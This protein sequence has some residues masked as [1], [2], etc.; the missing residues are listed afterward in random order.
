MNIILVIACL[1]YEQAIVLPKKDIEAANL[2]GL[3]LLFAICTS[4]FFFAIIQIIKQPILFIFNASQLDRYIW[5]IAPAILFGGIFSGLSYWNSRSKQ[6]GRIATA[7]IVS[8]IT[9]ISIQLAAGFNGYATGGSLIVANLMGSVAS[10]IILSSLVWRE[11]GKLFKKNINLEHM[12][13]GLYRYKKFPLLD[14]GS[15]LLNNISWQLPVL[16]FTVFF[17]S[18]VA[19][20]Y[21]L[22]FMAIQSP[23]SLIGGS[24]AQVFFQ[25][26]AIARGENELDIIVKGLF[27]FLILLSMFPMLSLAIIGR[28]L[29]ILL[30][31]EAWAE[32]GIYAQILSVWAIIWFVSGPMFTLVSVLEKQEYGFKFNVAI[33]ATRFLSIMIGVRFNSPRIAISLFAL[34]GILVYGYICLWILNESGVA[35]IEAIRILCHNLL[36]FIPAGIILLVIKLMGV[37]SLIEIGIAGIILILYFAIMVRDNRNY[38]SKSTETI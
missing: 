2:L 16:L 29:F 13:T 38:F 36:L 1:R 31:G 18:K 26:A 27:K 3:S 19:G 25:R 28:D 37:S 11:S 22:G 32:A 15:M 21:A 8:S 17:S 33:I 6:F 24:I 9:V 7:R 35:R 30:F 23:M 14:T 20:F 34:S 5:L 12:K 10:V 4:I